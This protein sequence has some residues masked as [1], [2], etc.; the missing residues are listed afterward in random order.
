MQRW[1]WTAVGV[2]LLGWS[3]SPFAT[4]HEI[5]PPT[6]PPPPGTALS[7]VHCDAGFADVFPCWNVDLAAYVPAPEFG[8]GDLNDL[9]GWTDPVSGAE[10]V[11]LGLEDGVAF[12]DASD[13]TAPVHLGTLPSHTNS[14]PW[15]D[16]KVYDD[17]VLAVSE[18]SGHGMQVFDLTRLAGVTAP[19]ETFAA[20]AHYGSFGDAHNLFVNEDTGYAYAVGANSCA[21][22]LH[23]IDVSDP[24]N[25]AF[26]GC[27]SA[28]GYTHDVQCVVYEGPDDDHTGD[29][30]CFASNEDTLTIV[31]V[32]DKAAPVQLSRTGY[33]GVAYVHQGWLSDDQRYFLHDDELDERDFGHETRTYVWD[34][35]DLEAP[36]WLGYHAGATGAIDHNHYLVGSHLYQANYRAGVRV[37]R[38][39]NLAAA[40]MAEIGFFDTY[41][42][43]DDALFTGVW[44]VY[45]YFASGVV[46]ASDITG[47]LFLLQPHLEHVTECADGIDNDSDGTTDGGD[48]GCEDA[49]DLSERDPSRPCDDGV[50]GDGDGFADYHVDPSQ[51]D[52]G[53]ASPGWSTE[54]PQC[55]D[56]LHNDGDGLM[57]YDGGLSIYGTSQTAADPQCAGKPWRNR[58]APNPPRACGLGF[59]NALLVAWLARRRRARSPKAMR[60]APGPRCTSNWR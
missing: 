23:M 30:I 39:G 48:P 43:D 57:D 51:R 59:E 21:R 56:G 40:E 34:V 6:G 35:S 2:A 1:R 36:L 24:L 15:R 11:I 28:D 18:A 31:D 13:P 19:P 44:G 53:C 5:D 20:D 54:S 52:P 22:G 26:A 12:V 4:G 42:N 8:G 47:G 9:W 49:A 38:L 45:P 50:D 7:N 37:L 33:A 3:L 27:F 55:Q 25:P 29:E 60:A 14:S 58:E 46:A 10:I 41:P 17:Y 16:V 32:T